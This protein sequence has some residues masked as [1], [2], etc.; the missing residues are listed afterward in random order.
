MTALDVDADPRSQLYESGLADRLGVVRASVEDPGALAR[1]VTEHGAQ[2]VFH[3]AARAIVPEARANPVATFEANIRGTWTLLDT[4]RQ[5]SDVV[6]EVVVASSDK[7]YGRSE[8]LPYTEEMPL[9]GRQPYEVSKACAD[10]LAQCYHHAYGLPVAVA[11]CGNVYG[12][13]DLNWSRLIPGTIA[14]LELGRRPDIRS[15]G[16]HIRDYIYVEDVAGAYIRLAEVLSE[17]SIGG[18]AFNFSTESRTTVLDIVD[19]L[20]S[21]MGCGHLEP[22]VRGTAEDEIPAQYLSAAKARSILKW[23]PQYDLDSGLPPT[24]EW[25]RAHLRRSSVRSA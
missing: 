4:C 5:C 22:D 17:D 24:I 8:N 11:R 15:D 16:T 19:K 1:T 7:A 21:L 2:T 14:A 13:G 3:L 23:N 25:Y 12:G 20:R 9:A 10:L 18:Q 6:S